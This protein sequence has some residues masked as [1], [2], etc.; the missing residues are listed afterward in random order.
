MYCTTLDNKNSSSSSCRKGKSKNQSNHESG[1]KIKRAK[2]KKSLT[3][4]IVQGKNLY[5]KNDAALLKAKRND[6]SKR[7]KTLH[8]KSNTRISNKSYT[9]VL[10]NNDYSKYSYLWQQPS[11]EVISLSNPN[12]D[13]SPENKD[14][15]N[16]EF[17]AL[18]PCK[19]LKLQNTW[20]LKK[21]Q[22]LRKNARSYT[23]LHND[24][25]KT[26]Y[27]NYDNGG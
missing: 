11:F 23:D 8:S 5:N 26:N 9:N 20:D 14:Y 21:L 22:E 13:S 18:I 12:K 19:D 15:N 2:T 1:K 10:I 17:N 25:L 24:R 7:H 27:V 4:H 6:S 3:K 16:E